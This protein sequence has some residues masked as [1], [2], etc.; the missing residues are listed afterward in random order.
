MLKLYSYYF[1][2]GNFFK[3]KFLSNFIFLFRTHEQFLQNIKLQKNP[4][5][6]KKIKK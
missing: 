5:N 6:I 2:I 4:L 1:S 3:S